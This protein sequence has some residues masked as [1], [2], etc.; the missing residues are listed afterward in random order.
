MIAPTN[1][2][3]SAPLSRLLGQDKEITRL[4]TLSDA[5][6]AFAVTLLVVSL[7]VPAT[8]NELLDAMRGFG[9]FAIC[10][11]FLLWIWHQHYRFFRRFRLED[12][13]TQAINGVLLFVVLFYVYPLK[14]LWT[15]L[16]QAFAGAPMTVARA[17]GLAEPVILLR[18][19]STLLVIYALGFIAVFLCFAFLYL[20]VYLKRKELELDEL[21][22]FDTRS[23]FWEYVGV[24][25][26]G[27]ISMLIAG[28]GGDRAAPFAGMSYSLVGVVKYVHGHQHAKRRSSLARRLVLAQAVANRS[29]LDEK[30]QMG[31]P[32][33]PRAAA[34]IEETRAGIPQPPQRKLDDKK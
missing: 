25:S 22:I 29:P 17:D 6:F 9:A 3:G 7:E 8:F 21:D 19:M 28:L 30:T 12:A 11:T 33:S 26:V 15:M 34:P 27:V 14:F 13:L 5:V 20:R 16:V 24:A 32:G 31:I 1:P 4:E 23:Y 10:F 18:Q 2:P